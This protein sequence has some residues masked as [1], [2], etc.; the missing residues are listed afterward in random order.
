MSIAATQMM[1]PF[2]LHN[3]RPLP[4]SFFYPRTFPQSFQSRF[5]DWRSNGGAIIPFT[6]RDGIFY[7]PLL[8][9]SHTSR[10][11]AKFITNFITKSPNFE[12]TMQQLAVDEYNSMRSQ[13]IQDPESPELLLKFFKVLDKM[14]FSG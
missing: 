13:P 8:L 12:R 10:D 5:P 14:F 9:Y 1:Q 7:A 2:I 6:L 4:Y 11:V 3:G